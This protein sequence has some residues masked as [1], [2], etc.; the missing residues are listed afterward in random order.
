MEKFN[1][2]KNC[3]PIIKSLLIFSSCNVIAILN[4]GTS[5]NEEQVVQD[6]CTHVK[7]AIVKEE[8]SNCHKRIFGK[9]RAC[10]KESPKEYNMDDVYPP[11]NWLTKKKWLSIWV[12]DFFKMQGQLFTWDSVKILIPSI[13]AYLGA[14]KMDED[15]QDCFYDSNNH[16]NV[17]QIPRALCEL[18]DKGIPVMIAILSSF[19]VLSNNRELRLTSF[20]YTQA[21]IAYWIAKNIFKNTCQYAYN[22]RPKNEHFCKKCSTYGGFPSGHTGEAVLAAIL[23]GMRHGPKWAVPLGLYSA[24]VFGVSVSANR[25]YVSQVVGGVALGALYG[26]AAYNLL[27]TKF[28][29]DI[30]CGFST[31]HKGNSVVGVSYSF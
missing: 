26:V 2:V 31:D 5:R 30:T 10:Y 23:F 1:K 15:L 8:L 17:H 20:T 13:P 25:H 21:T 6:N 27:K 28:P 24:L 7:P 3:Y 4:L 12:V 19:S 11:K 14:R 29:Y 22:L 9:S 16:K 18:S